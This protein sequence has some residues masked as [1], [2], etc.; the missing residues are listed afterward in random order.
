MD[1][2]LQ[3]ISLEIV[4][5]MKILAEQKR[6]GEVVP[7][8]AVDSSPLQYRLNSA[9]FRILQIF[10]TIPI[11]TTKSEMSFPTM[12]HIKTYLRNYMGEER[13]L[14]LAIISAHGRKYR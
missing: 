5:Q 11:I 6:K 7:D 1:T 8:Y 10:S 12:K 9:M 14:G 2:L 4:E 13:L 3:L